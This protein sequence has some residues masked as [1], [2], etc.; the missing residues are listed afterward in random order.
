MTP[1]MSKRRLARRLIPLQKPRPKQ[2]RNNLITGASSMMFDAFSFLVEAHY[3]MA[4]QNRVAIVT[5]AAHGIGEATAH[6]LSQQGAAV[7][8]VDIDLP[9]AEKV[10]EA[11]RAGGA[12]A[13]AFRCDVAKSAE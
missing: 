2:H 3:S 11:I 9:A 8:V 5:G 4:L 13:Q 1:A 12:K 7:A 10:A 6:V